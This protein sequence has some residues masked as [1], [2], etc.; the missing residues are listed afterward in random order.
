MLLIFCLIDLWLV[1]ASPTDENRPALLEIT[2]P[3]KLVENQTIRLNCD[4][5]QGS[6]PIR[7]SWHFNDEPIREDER[8]LQID[9]RS[10]SSSLMIKGLSA[11]SVGRYKCVA[12]NEYGSDQQTVEVHVNSKWSIYPFF[13][14]ESHKG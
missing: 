7:F 2:L 13:E 11:D 1:Q 10:D 12:A 9:T 8:Q 14:I 5:L 3:R 4:L 6:R